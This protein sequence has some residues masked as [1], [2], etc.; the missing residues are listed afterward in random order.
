MRALASI[1]LVSS[2]GCGQ[3]LV[4][5]PDPRPAVPT[6]SSTDPVDASTGIGLSRTIN[7]T[8]SEQMSPATITAATFTLKRGAASIAGG[9]TYAGRTATVVPTHRLDPSSTFTA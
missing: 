9:V 6:V 7:A 4:D 8:F 2:L 1:L 3:Q 5:F